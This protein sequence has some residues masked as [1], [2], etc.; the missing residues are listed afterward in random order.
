MGKFMKQKRKIRRSGFYIVSCLTL[1]FAFFVIK[2]FAGLIHIGDYSD[3]A[4]KIPDLFIKEEYDSLIPKAVPVD[5][6]E[7]EGY[8]PIAP[9]YDDALL[10]EEGVESKNAI[11]ICV[12]DDRVVASRLSQERMYPASMTKVM[13]LIVAVESIT[14]LTDT[15]TMTYEITDPLWEQN[16]TVMGLKSGETV[17][18]ID[19]LYGAILPSGA[20]ATQALAIYTAG[21]EEGF[22]EMMNEKAE[23]MGLLDTHFTNTSGLHNSEHYTT[24]YDMALILDYALNN[25]ICREILCTYKYTTT[26][27]PEHPEGIEMYSTM[28]NKVSSDQVEN[29]TILGGK[30]G[31]TYEAGHCLVSAAEKNGKTYIAV[32]GGGETKYTPIYDIIE[33]YSEYI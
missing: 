27:T 6:T 17:P 20:D 10:F 21:D 33:M 2:G 9:S 26:K 31:Y 18:L 23:E 12:D 22:V 5:V 16:A 7:D 24:A 30:T 3:I 11:L 28:F 32:T 29:V 14:D 1:V 13:S 4:E 8:V 19:L 25:E 15:F